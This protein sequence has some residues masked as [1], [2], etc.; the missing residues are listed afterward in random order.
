MRVVV[1]LLAELLEVLVLDDAGVGHGGI[2]VVYHG[3]A[4]VVGL[5]LHLGLEAHG[6][7]VEVTV[8]ILEELVELAG[9]DDRR[10]HLL[11]MGAVIEEVGVGAGVDTL[12]QSV[13]EAVVAS[14]GNAL[15]EVVEIVVV[16]DQPHGQSLDDEGGQ[17]GALAPPLLLGVALDE[18]LVD[19]AA[20]ERESLLLEVAR[21]GGS[22]GAHLRQ[23]LGALLLDLG[24]GLLG[25]YHA[26]HLVERVHVERQVVEPSLV[27]GHGR[28]GVSVEGHDAVDKVPH[29]LVGGVKDVGA[30]LVDV[31]ALHILAIDVAAEVR[32]LVDDKATGAPFMGEV[33]EGGT[34]EAGAHDEVVVRI[35]HGMRCLGVRWVDETLG[36]GMGVDVLVDASQ[37]LAL[38][39]QLLHALEAVSG[40]LPTAHALDIV[41]HPVAEVVLLGLVLGR[42]PLV[43]LEEEHHGVPHLVPA[44]VACHGL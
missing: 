9:V 16:V 31:D 3:V 8:T 35:R 34:E 28:V 27:V 4:L 20:D 1:D 42:A 2:S 19:V 40:H 36:L 7:E 41:F 39:E 37:A 6:A 22:L 24:G 29:T 25:S 11:P 15:V 10:R 44:F 13:D 23:G 21:L 14:H 26:P 17:L 18:A 30:I 33:G 43:L 32:S 38:V 5:G 12:Q